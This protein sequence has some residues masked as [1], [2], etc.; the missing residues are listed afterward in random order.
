[1]VRQ[2]IRKVRERLRQGKGNNAGNEVTLSGPVEVVEGQAVHVMESAADGSAAKE[3][4]TKPRPRR[5]RRP[6]S[7]QARPPK[8]VKDRE[9]GTGQEVAAP[10][11]WDPRVFEVEPVAGETRFHDLALPD[12]IMHAIYDLGFK[13]CTP[14]QAES[15]PQV[16]TG[17]DLTGKAQTGT[18]KS[19]AF[20]IAMLTRLLANPLPGKRENGTPRAL[21]LAPTREL[22]HQIEKDAK[23]LAAHSTIKTAAVFGGMD[24]EKQRRQLSEQPVDIMVATPGRL[25]DFVG[26]QVVRLKKVE[27]LVID[28]A[29]RM[30]DMGFI[31]DVRRIVHSTPEKSRRQT[32]FFSATLTD[33]VMRLA[34]QWTKDPVNVEIEP[35]Q[36]TVETVE[37]KVYM[38]TVREKFVLLYNLI[39]QERL[40]RVMIFCNRRDETRRLQEKL[41]R[42][43]ISCSLLSGD[44]P[45]KKRMKTL[46]DF[47]GGKVRVLVATDVAGRGIH[48]DGISHVVNFNLPMDA[49]DY[50]HRIGRTAR[51]GAAGISISFADE[52]EAFYLPDIEKFIGRKLE[53]TYPE[54]EL[55]AK[56]PPAPKRE[57]KSSSP[58]ASKSRRPGGGRSR[59]GSRG[60]GPRGG[61]SRSRG[62]RSRT[63]R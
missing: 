46:E 47:R 48:I 41:T 17:S 40:T 43:G 2:L 10:S 32:L 29:D 16:L 61:G 18:G 3:D 36:V 20:L 37:Q 24:Y 57:V 5:R 45:Q 1:M 52:D 9:E 25:L 4:G 63:S 11:P 44:V 55:L 7:G 31:P 42:Y 53:C 19:A 34:E 62:S 15:L 56:L 22:V 50:V 35:E 6:K 38:V 26:Q 39:T 33:D 12:E 14:I 60:G 59:T 54:E 58:A 30:L 23:D 49:E 13:Y 27:I 51:A 8:A 28:E 21:I